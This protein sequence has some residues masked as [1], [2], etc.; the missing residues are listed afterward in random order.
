[1]LLPGLDGTGDLFDAL[2]AA[3]PPGV[4][5]HGV[6]LPIDRPRTYAELAA[7]IELP[8]GE[9]VLVAESFS[10]PLA[11]LLAARHARVR[12]VV[13]CASFVTAPVW[14]GLAGLPDAMLGR[15]PPRA[16]VRA[17]LT[18][19][20]DALAARVLASLAKVPPAIV[21]SRVR[22]VLSVD[23]AQTLA[24][25]PQPVTLLAATRDRLVP[26]RSLAVMR[27]LR[28]EAPVVEVEA[29]HL[30]LQ[31]RPHEAWRGLVG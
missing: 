22:A 27:S 2:V 10:G 24:E 3:A 19:G 15:T 11:V 25:L 17:M 26:R 8:P 12:R 5:T 16:A 31:T 13:L 4:R 6:A 14:S 9:L 7:A 21:A 29:P 30:L 23:V 28:P 18:G 20:D 1:M